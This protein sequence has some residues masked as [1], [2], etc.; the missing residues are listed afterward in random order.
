MA[1]GLLALHFWLHFFY[2]K[3]G[4]GDSYYYPARGRVVGA[5]LRESRASGVDGATI[6]RLHAAIATRR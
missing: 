3:K 2:A 4:F 6:E 1:F 5:A